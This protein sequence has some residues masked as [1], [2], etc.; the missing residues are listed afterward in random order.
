MNSKRCNSK[1]Y[2]ESWQT[3]PAPNMSVL[4]YGSRGNPYT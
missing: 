1:D 2:V 3:I 4:P